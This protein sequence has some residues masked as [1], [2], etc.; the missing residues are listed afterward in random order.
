MSIADVC[1]FLHTL[2]PM[3]GVRSVACQSQSAPSPVT[4]LSEALWDMLKLTCTSLQVVS[5]M[6][7]LFSSLLEAQ[8][9]T[10]QVNQCKVCLT[11]IIP[12]RTFSGSFSHPSFFPH[13]ILRPP[14]L[15][16]RGRP[17]LPE[18]LLTG[19]VP[20]LGYISGGGEGQMP[21]AGSSLLGV[22]PSPALPRVRE[23]C[24]LAA[25]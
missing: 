11:E 14:S 17:V 19:P 9:A 7:G 24:S 6:R 2:S 20:C 5:E 22:H 16:S 1:V 15:S 3:D 23:A 8:R 25:S 12:P 21:D 13:P 10:V 18:N 4:K